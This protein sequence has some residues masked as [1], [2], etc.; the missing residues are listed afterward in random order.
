ML[1]K[2]GLIAGIFCIVSIL[3]FKTLF[4][5]LQINISNAFIVIE[6]IFGSHERVNIQN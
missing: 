6:I 5:T 3:V 2:L 4:V 1:S